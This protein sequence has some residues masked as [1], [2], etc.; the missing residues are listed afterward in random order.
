MDS[1][2]RFEE[3]RAYR[4]AE[5]I[6][7]TRRYWTWVAISVVAFSFGILIGVIIFK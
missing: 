4:G 6:A 1:E 5:Q 7:A 2:E 3:W